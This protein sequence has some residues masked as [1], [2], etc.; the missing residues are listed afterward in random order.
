[1]SNL[2]ALSDER[3]RRPIPIGLLALDPQLKSLMPLTANPIFTFGA[4][5]V[6]CLLFCYF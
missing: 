2:T 3:R 5:A 6:R 4:Y 1:M